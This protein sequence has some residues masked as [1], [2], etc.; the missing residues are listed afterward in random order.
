MFPCLRR[1]VEP[2]RFAMIT[3]K[4]IRRYS[5]REVARIAGIFLLLG[6]LPR[7]AGAV[8]APTLNDRFDYL[9]AN[10]NSTCSA[11]FTDSIARMAVTARLQGSC[12]TPIER[13]RYVQ[14]VQGLTK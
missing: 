14:Q 11:V 7:R 8:E 13:H 10:G 2:G 1:S 3:V 9:S 6:S 12:C 5:R 4:P